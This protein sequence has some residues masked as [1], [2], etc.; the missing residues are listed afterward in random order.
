MRVTEPITERSAGAPPR[1]SV[2][3]VSLN[4]GAL[5]DQCVR[6]LAPQIA[7]TAIEVI[8]VRASDRSI[9]LDRRAITSNLPGLQWI[10]APAG[11]TVPRLRGLGIAAARGESVALIEDDCMVAA[12]W[13]RQAMLD[14][15]SF[16]AVGGA[17]E[18]GPYRRAL[19][20]AVYFCE[21]G[22]FM[23][24]VPA[25]PGA[26]LPGTNVVYSG[27]ALAALPAAARDDFHDVFV[28]ARWHR[29]SVPTRVNGSLVVHNLNA[30]SVADVTSGPFHHGRAYSAQRFGPRNPLVRVGIALLILGLPILKVAR[31][32][33]DTVSRRRLIGRLALAL[34]W[35]GVFVVSW[36]AGELAGCLRGPGSSPS[37]W[38]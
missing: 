14:A 25:S 2:V 21:F 13:C 12:D 3:I 33:S 16:A 19:D 5:L 20:W 27:R 36:S 26:P 11:T 24:P 18:P 38:R 7:S 37:R 34:P 1:L 8:V 32:M 23:L 28:H 10:D 9:G 4:D 17:V 6:T 22:R 15:G 31:I 29:D 30:W 35:I